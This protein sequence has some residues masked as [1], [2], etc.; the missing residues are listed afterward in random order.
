MLQNLNQDPSSGICTIT[1]FNNADG[2]LV[3]HTPNYTIQQGTCWKSFLK[4]LE[5][6][7]GKPCICM[8][9]QVTP[10]DLTYLWM[11]TLQPM[12]LDLP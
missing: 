7:N 3:T 9:I 5:D 12:Y 11:E 10:Q 8:T 1:S 2:I 4:R 6:K